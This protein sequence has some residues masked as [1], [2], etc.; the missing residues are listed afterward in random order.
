MVD[1]SVLL[2]SKLLK[3]SATFYKDEFMLTIKVRLVDHMLGIK[4]KPYDMEYFDFLKEVYNTYQDYDDVIDCVVFVLAC[5]IN[6]MC[7]TYAHRRV[8][9]E[10]T[11][12]TAFNEI[13]NEIEEYTG[14]FSEYF[15]DDFVWDTVDY[16]NIAS[17]LSHVETIAKVRYH[18]AIDMYTRLHARWYGYHK[19]ENMIKSSILRVSE[20]RL[21][22]SEAKE[23]LSFCLNSTKFNLESV[24]YTKNCKLVGFDTRRMEAHKKERVAKEVVS[25]ETNRKGEQD[26]KEPEAI[27]RTTSSGDG[28]DSRAVRGTDGDTPIM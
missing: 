15:I 7:R 25:D 12:G 22:H 8:S 24:F 10:K 27:G 11:M 14:F 16:D 28:E 5:E 18:L 23:L 3:E 9:M 19:V 21:R 26:Y 4:D 1:I 13:K 6:Y 20:Q 17:L 2:S